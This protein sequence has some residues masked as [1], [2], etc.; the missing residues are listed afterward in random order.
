[1]K[2]IKYLL[3]LSSLLSSIA[4]AGG[5]IIPYTPTESSL[6]VGIGASAIQ[7]TD[8]LT[9]ETL[10]A[11]GVTALLGY[12]INEYI[13]IEG[14]YTASVSDVE[15][16]RGTTANLNNPAYPT[17]Y[18]NMALYLKPTY[19]IDS[20]T[21]YALI[22]YGMTKFTDLPTGTRDREESGLQWG[23]GASYGITDNI[24]LFADYTMIYD[25]TGFDGHVPFSGINIDVVSVGVA[26]RF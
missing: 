18:T 16:D 12:R 11:T 25:D 20:F 19:T 23:L 8:E 14:R 7:L 13:S 22:G 6:Y 26:Y 15:Y 21:A 5:V 10:K 4:H 1:M 9:D 17:G 2:R 24:S 3:V